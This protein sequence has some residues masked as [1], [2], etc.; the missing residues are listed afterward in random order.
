MEIEMTVMKTGISWTNTTWSPTVGCDKISA[1][2]DNCYAEAITRRWGQ[3]FNDIRLHHNRLNHVRLFRPIEKNGEL[4][5]RMV[6][7]NSMSDLHHESIPDNFRHRVY[8]AIEGNAQTIFQILTKRPGPMR[9]FLRERY[10]N[11]ATP[12]H[13]WFGVSVEDNRV[14]KRI[15]LLRAAKERHTVACAFLSIEPLIGPVEECDLSAMDW[16]LIGGESGPKCRD[17]KLGWLTTAIDKSRESG[18]AIWFKQ[19]GHERNNPYVQAI[20]AT[21]RRGVREAF[22]LAVQR[23]LELLPDEKGGATIAG[24]IYRELPGAWFQM[25]SQ[26]HRKLQI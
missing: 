4:V 20:M 12:A 25:K 18:A 7:V 23:G 5:P 22:R 11:R 13:L 10:G 6:F 1:G 9:R 8:D 16:V 14:K 24:N 17:M 2:C 21:E 26:I 19:Y 3:E 15:D